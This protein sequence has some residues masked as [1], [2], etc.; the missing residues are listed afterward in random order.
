MM[1]LSKTKFSIILPVYNVEKYLERCIKS[2]LKQTYTNFE[3]ICV[4]DASPDNSL[5]ILERFAKFDER[6]LIIINP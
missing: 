5:Q 2:I 6:I 4:N 3:L 1:D